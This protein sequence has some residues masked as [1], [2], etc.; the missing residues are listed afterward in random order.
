MWESLELLRAPGEKLEPPPGASAYMRDIIVALNAAR[1]AFT[2]RDAL[3]IIEEPWTRLKAAPEEER[4]AFVFE[5]LT[6]FQA[7][8]TITFELAMKG[9]ASGLLRSG[10]RLSS[11][12]A[13]RLVD[14]VSRHRQRFPYKALLSA[15]DNLTLTPALREALLRLRPMIDEWHG[16]TDMREIHQRIDIL[17]YG[18][19]EKPAA[20]VSGWTRQVFEEVDRSSKQLSWRGLLLH[21]RSLTQSSAPKKWQ[22]EAVEYV[23]RIGREEFFEAAHR[24]L[25]LGPMPGMPQVQVPEEE[26]DYQKGFIWTLGALG[27]TS[28][29]GEIA[30]FAFACFRKIPQIGAVSHRVGNA[31]VNA[32][33]A[34]PGLDAVIQIRRLGMRVKYDVARR[35][36]EKA[37]MQAGSGTMSVATIWRRCRFRRWG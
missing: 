36:I 11:L 2:E 15:I 14:L 4:V 35:L 6:A 17:V 9:V 37:L 5:A 23:E 34:M 21:A 3:K 32:L 22:K 8:A 13:V 25:A 1:P 26:A 28:V 20:A 16:G 31:C 10:L 18:A 24:W 30:D 29:A 7:P 27:D 19:K 33:A 12:D